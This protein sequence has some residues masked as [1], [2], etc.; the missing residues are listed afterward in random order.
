[1]IKKKKK[2]KK[3]QICKCHATSA[4]TTIVTRTQIRPYHKKVKDC[5]S[6]IIY[7]NLVDFEFLMLYTKIQPLRFHSS[8]EE[9]F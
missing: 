2:K 4:S 1:M 5:T 8:G 6:N 3:L 9:D 7:T